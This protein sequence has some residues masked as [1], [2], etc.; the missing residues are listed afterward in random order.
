MFADESIVVH[1]TAAHHAEARRDW[2]TGC[3]WE[4][5]EHASQKMR[6][7]PALGIDRGSGRASSDPPSLQLSMGFVD[8]SESRVEQRWPN[9]EQHRPRADDDQADSSSKYPIGGENVTADCGLAL[10]AVSDVPL[11]SSSV[12]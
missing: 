4:R 9:T 7:S 8:F 1:A 12:L 3:R 11:G 5:E 2:I 10:P 6:S